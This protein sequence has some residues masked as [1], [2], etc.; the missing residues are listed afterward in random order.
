MK[1]KTT[2]PF[3]YSLAI[4]SILGFLAIIGDTWFNFN[5]L[6]KNLSPLIL[7][8]LGVGLIIEGQIRRWKHFRKGGLTSNEISHIVTGVVGIISLIIGLL[9]LVN[10]TN[11]T[12][13]AMKG[14]ISS[15][16]IVIIMV[17][18]WVVD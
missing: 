3:L 12:F 13:D 14:V 2:T 9:S 10:F 11:P 17:E 15:I 18:T 1:N 6:D 4:I 16:G 8:T 7:I 5:F